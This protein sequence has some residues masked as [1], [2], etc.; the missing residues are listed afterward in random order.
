MTSFWCFSIKRFGTRPSGVE[1]FFSMKP[2]Y[3]TNSLLSVHRSMWM[4]Q[5]FIH[6]LADS[7]SMGCQ[8][9]CGCAALG[10]LR[11]NTLHNQLQFPFAQASRAIFR[12]HDRIADA[13]AA[14]ALSRP[15]L[16]FENE[17]HAGLKLDL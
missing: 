13:R 3:S 9:G 17:N 16:R 1:F 10:S 12:H 8:L 6:P 7:P 2:F 4:L 11:L 15:H 5:F 14:F